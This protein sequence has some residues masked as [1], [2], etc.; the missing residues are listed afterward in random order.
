MRPPAHDDDAVKVRTERIDEQI[1]LLQRLRASLTQ[2][3]GCGCLSLGRCQLSNPGDRL[4]RLGPGPR[5]WLSDRK[6][7]GSS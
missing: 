6:R 7:P 2:C 5:Y 3:I 1:V 4:S